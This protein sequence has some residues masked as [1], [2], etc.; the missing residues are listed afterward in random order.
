MYKIKLPVCCLS[1]Y[2]KKPSGVLLFSWEIHNSVKHRHEVSH[3]IIQFIDYQLTI[4]SPPCVIV[5]PVL[6][7]HLKIQVINVHQITTGFQNVLQIHKLKYTQLIHVNY[8]YI[9]SHNRQV[10]TCITKYNNTHHRLLNHKNKLLSYKIYTITNMK[11]HQK[12]HNSV[13]V[14]HN[15]YMTYT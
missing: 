11:D 8:S 1:P 4:P 9:P 5:C 6:I 3:A 15:I 14:I 7:S 10:N 13:D 2:R 12:S